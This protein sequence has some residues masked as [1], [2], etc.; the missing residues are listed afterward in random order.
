[1]P[2]ENRADVLVSDIS[3]IY[4]YRSMATARRIDAGLAAYPELGF[5]WL[6]RGNVV[7]IFDPRRKAK[8]RRALASLR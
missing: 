5:G 2:D 4:V 3:V 6:R 1:M 7:A 8:V